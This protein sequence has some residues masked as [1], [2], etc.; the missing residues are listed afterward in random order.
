MHD[1]PLAYAEHAP[2]T[3]VANPPLL[4]LLHGY[5]A[6]E[7]DLIGLAPMLDQRLLTLSPRA[8]LV[9]AP[10]AFAWFEIAFTGQGIAV[11]PR[12][13]ISNTRGNR[14]VGHNR[15]VISVPGVCHLGSR[16]GAYE[17]EPIMQP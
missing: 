7:H 2:A 11:D 13:R 9:L 6:N 8:P 17:R 14:G 10:F 15:V 1:L 12:R 3:P 5:G 16:H 4:V